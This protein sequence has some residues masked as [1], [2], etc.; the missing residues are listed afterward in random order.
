M[1]RKGA[2]SRSSG[3]AIFRCGGRSGRCVLQQLD[4]S[5]LPA[6]RDGWSVQ[7]ARAAPGEPLADGSAH[8]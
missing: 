3:F 6:G 4:V 1:S 8:R 5:L 2:V 7:R